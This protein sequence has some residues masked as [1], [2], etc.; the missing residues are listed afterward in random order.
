MA[1]FCALERLLA[2]MLERG[3]RVAVDDS[4]QTLTYQAVASKVE[5]GRARLKQAGL[6]EGDRVSVIVRQK[7]TD[8]VNLLAVMAV[9]AVAVPCDSLWPRFRQ[10]Q[11]EVD[12]GARS[13]FDGETLTSLTAFGREGT[14]EDAKALALLVYTS[15]SK[16]EPRGVMVKPDNIEFCA[17]NIGERLGYQATDR[18]ACPIRLS[19]DYGLYQIFLA[20]NVGA[21]LY[22]RDASDPFGWLR[23]AVRTARPTILVLTPSIARAGLLKWQSAADDD[24]V[25]LVTFTGEA[26]DRRVVGAVAD[27]FRRS[28]TVLMYGVTECKRVSISGPD[29]WRSD[30]T[31]V[32]R[33]LTGTSVVIRD[34]SGRGVSVGQVGEIHVRGPNVSSG[35]WNDALLSAQK[36]PTYSGHR[37]LATEDLGYLDTSGRLHIVGRIGDIYKERGERIS[38]SEVEEAALRCSG[39]T[40]AACIPPSEGQASVLFVAV[41]EDVSHEDLIGGLSET[42]GASR[43]PRRLVRV[44][45]LPLTPNGKA[46]RA[47]LRRTAYEGIGGSQ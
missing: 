8:V 4:G 40:G 19:F 1:K 30:L 12:A 17:R 21:A 44:A 31:A 5:E 16:A 41:D 24:G 7:C 20:F 26:V 22:L 10:I 25:R 3:E 27:A 13:R 28:A 45:E 47:R 37:E 18:I 9:G 42:L 43:L 46:D 32:G 6:S 14:S 34:P 35:Y 38:T 15:G 2:S 33:P 36:F 39:V 29:E 23:A 11:T